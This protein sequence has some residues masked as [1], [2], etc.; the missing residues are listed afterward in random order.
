MLGPYIHEGELTLGPIGPEH[1]DNFCAWFA[2]QEV[3][4]YLLMTLPPSLKQEQE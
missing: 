2:D 1:L 3:T 4:R